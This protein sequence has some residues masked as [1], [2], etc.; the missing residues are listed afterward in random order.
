MPIRMKKS[1]SDSLS[2][3]GRLQLTLAFG[4]VV[5]LFWGFRYPFAL[6]YQE[7]LQ[8][9]L[10]DGGYFCSRMAEPGGFARYVAEFLVQFYNG[11]AIGAAIL[12]LLYMLVQW[13]TWRLM[14][15]TKGYYLLSFI[16][17]IILWYAMG[18]ESVMLTY[19]VALVMAL[20]TALGWR[21]VKYGK[22]TRMVL[23]VVLIPVLY[24]LIGPMVLLVAALMLPWV[25]AVP[26]FLYALAL[27]LLSA[28][29]LPF[30]MSR[31]LLGISYY[32]FPETMPYVL[33][34]IPVVVWLLALF[35]RKLSQ[36]KQWVVYVLALVFAILVLV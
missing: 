8:L 14:Q 10:F 21:Q 34:A 15:A 13:L 25:V 32:R 16:P 22:L 31:V 19:V 23:A 5:F 35:M 7:Q 6:T 20:A 28:H 12:A 33:I 4:L 3:H 18:D 2:K 30:P 29:F 1:L 26:A 36:P 27:I 24:W 11:A 17:A 9:F